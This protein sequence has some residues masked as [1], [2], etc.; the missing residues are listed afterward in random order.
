MNWLLLLLSFF[1]A[2]IPTAYYTPKLIRVIKRNRSLLRPDMNKIGTPSIPSLGG[3]A[4]VTGFMFSLTTAVLLSLIFKLD[5]VNA[6]LLLPG[7]LSIAL[8]A[9]MGLVDDVVMIP[10]RFIKPILTLYATIPMMALTGLA[11]QMFLPFF[12]GIDLGIFYYLAFIPLAIIFCSNAVNILST[13]NGLETGMALIASLGLLTVAIIKGQFLGTLILISLLAVLLVFYNYNRFPAKIFLGNVGTLF[14]GAAIAVGA[15]LGN[16]ER[17]LIIVMIP[18]FIHFLFYSRNFYRFK[19]N[20]WAVPQKDGTL[21]CPYK[22]PM[23]LMHLLIKKGINTEK[24]VTL[25]LMGLEL[26]FVLAA[27]L[28]ELSGL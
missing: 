17:A 22:K 21:K 13:Y 23:G 9:L 20:M 7:V 25:Y 24:K 8:I 16:I 12:G 10:K 2:L 6:Q 27:V 18:Y 11:T 26:V 28:L 1:L 19:P 5:S 3:I 14:V 15:I 4:I